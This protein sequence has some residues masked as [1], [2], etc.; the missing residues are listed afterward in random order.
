VANMEQEITRMHASLRQRGYAD[1]ARDF[2]HE[3]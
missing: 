1:W 3:E 2:L